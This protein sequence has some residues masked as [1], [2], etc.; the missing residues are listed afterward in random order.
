MQPQTEVIDTIAKAC[1]F[2]DFEALQRFVLADP[3][4]AN[5]ADAQGYYP[6]QWAALN[7]RIQEV[8]FLISKGGAVNQQD[9]TGQTALHWAA[10]RG[11]LPVIETLLRSDA[12]IEI[13]DNRGY[14]ACHVAAQY[15]QTAALY[16]LA[17]KWGVDI[18]KEDSDGRTPIHWAAYKGLLTPSA[19]SSSSMLDIPTPIRKAAPLS[20][21]Q[22]S[23]AMARHAPFFSRGAQSTYSIRR[24]SPG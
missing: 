18:D 17:L 23:R 10:V 13:K 3:T 19:S 1:A 12:D 14:T 11:S 7:N 24:T 4:A 8:S 16:H 20:T 21:G 22:Q 5:T 2:G 9:S 15:G 6:L